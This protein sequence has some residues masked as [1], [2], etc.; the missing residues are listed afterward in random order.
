MADSMVLS[1]VAEGATKEATISVATPTAAIVR[2]SVLAPAAVD[3]E[4]ELGLTHVK[5]LAIFGDEGVTM[6]L[7][8]GTGEA[9]GCDPVFCESFEDTD[10]DAV[11]I[12]LSNAGALSAEVTICAFGE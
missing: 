5:A 8:A 11:S 3:V 10:H 2:K 4:I 6:R 7:T 9:H 12:F 1:V